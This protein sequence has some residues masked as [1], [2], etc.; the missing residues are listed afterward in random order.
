MQL[1][2][3]LLDSVQRAAPS[4]YALRHTA[5]HLTRVMGAPHGAHAQAAAA[6][7]DSLLERRA[8]MQEVVSSPNRLDALVRALVALP[9]EQHTL[10]SFDVRMWLRTQRHALQADAA[11]MVLSAMEAAPLR[12]RLQR[13][14]CAWALE[15]GCEWRMELTR[16]RWGACELVVDLT[17]S[18]PG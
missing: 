7:L 15:V 12:S 3:F 11:R 6:K 13:V 8:Y 10:L 17:V 5:F 14:A 9:N 2:A 4:P 16:S 18:S 1:G